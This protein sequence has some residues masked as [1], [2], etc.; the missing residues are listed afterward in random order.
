MIRVV[1][2]QEV[3]AWFVVFHPTSQ[4]GWVNRI[5]G[6]FKH[7]SAFCVQNGIML[8]VSTDLGRTRM[9]VVQEGPTGWAF[10][11]DWI[12]DAEVVR[13]PVQLGAARNPR[14]GLWCVPATAHLCGIRSGALRP[15]RLWEDC[16]AIGERIA[17]EPNHQAAELQA[18]GVGDRRQAGCGAGQAVVDPGDRGARHAHA[19]LGLWLGRAA[20]R[21]AALAQV[22]PWL[23]GISRSGGRT[24]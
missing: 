24:R 13:V 16:V 15:D 1:E 18:L 8:F 4:W 12:G 3:A 10:A 22:I 5:P 19:G 9:C 6:R 17:R 21:L 14:W 11:A 7:V 23:T 20:D 2:V